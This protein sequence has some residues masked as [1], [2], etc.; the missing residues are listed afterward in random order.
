[1]A[2][3]VRLADLAVGQR[4]RV[5]DVDCTGEV[6]Q[7]ILEMGLTPGVTVELLGVAPLGDPLVFQVRGYRLGL[8]KVEAAL[9]GIERI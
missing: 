1:M 2:E 9:V 7:R 5:V 8:R 6:G 4:G 3:G